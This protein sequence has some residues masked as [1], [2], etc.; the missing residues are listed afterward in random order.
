MHYSPPPPPPLWYIT[1]NHVLT[2]LKPVWSQS[3]PIL[4][5]CGWTFSKCLSNIATIEK[6]HRKCA[7]TKDKFLCHIWAFWDLLTAVIALRCAKVHITAPWR[8]SE[9]PYWPDGGQGGHVTYPP[10]PRAWYTTALCPDKVFL[11]LAFLIATAVGSGVLKTYVQKMQ[12]AMWGFYRTEKIGQKLVP[13]TFFVRFSEN[14]HCMMHL[15]NFSYQPLECGV[16]K[17]AYR[18]SWRSQKNR[19]TPSTESDWTEGKFNPHQTGMTYSVT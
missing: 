14:I 18:F 9:K 15:V 3:A 11:N 17:T 4:F 7:K 12:F 19:R 13:G 2:S 8:G 1:F 5:W 6:K 10:P 16:H